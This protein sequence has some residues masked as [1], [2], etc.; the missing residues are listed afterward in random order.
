MATGDIIIIRKPITMSKDIDDGNALMTIAT[1]T[2]FHD[3]VTAAITSH[4]H[5]HR[6]SK[7]GV[8][9]ATLIV[10]GIEK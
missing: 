7:E 3:T 8:V 2:V 5:I 10:S 6:I 9:H 4:I 1:P